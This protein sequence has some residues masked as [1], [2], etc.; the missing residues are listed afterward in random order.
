MKYLS[1]FLLMAIQNV[2]GAQI[3]PQDLSK[4]LK[5][6]VV[7]SFCGINTGP[8]WDVYTVE[9]LKSAD[10]VK[11][12]N[13]Y[14]DGKALSKKSSNWYKTLLTQMKN[15]VQESKT[16]SIDIDTFR[17][18]HACHLLL[19]YSYDITTI[20]GGDKNCD[21]YKDA[22]LYLRTPFVTPEGTINPIIKSHL[23][24]RVH[25]VVKWRQEESGR[26]LIAGSC[27]GTY[28]RLL[29]EFVECAD[30]G[31]LTEFHVSPLEEEIEEYQ[32]PSLTASQRLAN[33]CE[34]M[35]SL[36]GHNIAGKKNR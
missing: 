4:E 22:Q 7:A 25:E 19:A 21:L 32:Q 8:L 17:A 20:Y 34:A 16:G 33:A 12:F 31:K 10:D 9:R 11:R 13:D 23:I 26:F 3:N 6:C 5:S 35:L 2:Y 27:M 30:T 15:R 28:A 24:N 36:F 14:C 18:E 29:A 1:L